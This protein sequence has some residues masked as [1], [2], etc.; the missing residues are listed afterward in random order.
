VVV[1]KFKA[2]YKEEIPARCKARMERS[3]AGPLLYG[4]S[5]NG[6]YHLC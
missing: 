1:M 6:G 2:P 5:L 4:I 3:T